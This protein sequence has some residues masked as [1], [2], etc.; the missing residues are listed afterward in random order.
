MNLKQIIIYLAVLFIGFALGRVSHILGG[1]IN[2]PHHWMF[3]TLLIIAGII[4]WFYKREWSLYLIFFGIG[5]TI[6]D[7]KDMLDFKI[8]GVD[9]PGPKRF[10]HID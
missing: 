7:L 5:L 6:S 4:L 3:G 9:P 1:Q 10:W 2:G 8:W